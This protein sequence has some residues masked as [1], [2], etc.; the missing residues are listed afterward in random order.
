MFLYSEHFLSFVSMIFIYLS[1]ASFF[2]VF[3]VLFQSNKHEAT[4]TIRENFLIS[5]VSENRLLQKKADKLRFNFFTSVNIRSCLAME[6]AA[7]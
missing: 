5:S 7:F 2:D 6:Q 1:N 3:F 4:H